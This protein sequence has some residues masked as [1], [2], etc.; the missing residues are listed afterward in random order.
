MSTSREID[1]V[2]RLGTEL[3]EVLLAVHLLRN[4][5]ADGEDYLSNVRN[6]KMI[7]LLVNDI[8]VRLGKFREEDNRN[9]SFREAAK[10]LRKKTSSAGRAAAAEQPIQEFVQGSKKLEDYR[11][12]AIAHLAKRGASHLKPLTEL[13]QLVALAVNVV[14]ILSGEKNEY[15]VGEVDLRSGIARS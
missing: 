10:A 7:A 15:R 8:V 2:Q 12:V 9:W 14:D 3:L 1:S 5:A 6:T 4:P 11:N 13:Y